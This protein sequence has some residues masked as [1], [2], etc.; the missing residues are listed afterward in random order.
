MYNLVSYE[1]SPI[2]LVAIRGRKWARCRKRT[3]DST[4]DAP[5]D[6]LPIDSQDSY[7]DL[8]YRVQEGSEDAAWELVQ[9]Y[10]G[11][12]RRAVRRVLDRRL[13]PKF[14]SLDFVQLVWQSFLV[15]TSGSR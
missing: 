10:G 5:A 15:A 14:D 1:S 2:C 12:V 8:M 7:R 3:K 11:Y 13:R 9:R 4:L 6:L